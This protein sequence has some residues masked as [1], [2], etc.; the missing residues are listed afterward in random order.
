M[1]AY[2]VTFGLLGLLLTVGTVAWLFQTQAIRF[3]ASSAVPT[4]I[5]LAS[6]YN[7]E[8]GEQRL[9]LNIQQEAKLKEFAW[10][11]P[12]HEWVKVPIESAIRELIYQRNAG[13]KK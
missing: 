10:L 4:A 1:K 11:D 2:F 3:R 8:N 12:Q 13:A 5:P 7:F 9:A 6:I